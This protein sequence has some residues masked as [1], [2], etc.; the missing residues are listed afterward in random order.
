[1]TNY[2]V[3]SGGEREEVGE[4]GGGISKGCVSLQGRVCKV[5]F[6]T[7][8][9][10]EILEVGRG[11]RTGSTASILFP[12]YVSTFVGGCTTSG[13]WQ[14]LF[15]CLGRL[16]GGVLLASGSSEGTAVL[17]RGTWGATRA[18]GTV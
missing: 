15:S 10:F 7:S 2:G 16:H 3:R 4:R 8:M 9:T 5:G 6:P 18:E 11:E 14:P 12:E 13:A 1:M 17:G